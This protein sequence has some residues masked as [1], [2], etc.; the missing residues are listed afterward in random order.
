MSRQKRTKSDI[1]VKM[2]RLC[3]SGLKK[4]S[5]EITVMLLETDNQYVLVTNDTPDNDEKM[6][7]LVL[8]TTDFTEGYNQ[9]LSLI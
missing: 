5:V 9:F 2:T 6:D 8:Q 1:G 3:A 7:I 4:G